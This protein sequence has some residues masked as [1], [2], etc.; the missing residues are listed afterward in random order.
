MKYVTLGYDE[1]HKVV[2]TNR[3]LNWDGFTITTWRKDPAGYS[4]RRGEFHRG[5][6]GITFRYPLRAD[7]T[8]K[9]PENYVRI[10]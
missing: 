2:D 8:W 9:V 4:D 3:F 7:G 6:W 5:S 10:K 1:A